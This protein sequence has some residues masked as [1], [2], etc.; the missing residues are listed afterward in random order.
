MSTWSRLIESPEEIPPIYR[1][2]FDEYIRSDRP[3][4]H[5]VLTPSLDKFPRKTSEKLVVDTGEAVH[6]FERN[7]TQI[8]VTLFSYADV[9]AVE[10]GVVLLDSWLTIHGRTGDGN[11]AASTIQFNTTSMRHFDGMLR[12]MRPAPQ[13]V[14]L[15]QLTTEKDKFDVL[16]GAS[17]KFM[18]YGRES[19]VSGETVRQILLQPEIHQPLWTVFGRTFS[20]TLSP[21]HL[22]VLTDRELI[23]IR[24]TE[25]VRASHVDRYGGIW[26]Y[27][28]LPRIDSATIS[29][30]ANERWLLSIRH[31]PGRTVEQLFEA[32]NHAAL[33]KLVSQLREQVY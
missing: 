21:T 1:P 25:R 2:A 22:T 15:S 10:M 4:P 18:N 12:K 20:K 24:N 14:N 6:I 8:H 27:I 26:Q 29:P 16:A 3:F 5:V 19:L 17:F 9:C 33:E 28:P 31:Q 13:V 32:S 23:L 7:R 11:V 30:A